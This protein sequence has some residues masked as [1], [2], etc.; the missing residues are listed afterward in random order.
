[1]KLKPECTPSFLTYF[2]TAL[3][4]QKYVWKGELN[5]GTYY[6]LPFTSGCKLKKRSKKNISIKTVELVYRTDSGEL[7][8]T[9]EL[10]L[11]CE[12]LYLPAPKNLI[13]FS[14]IKY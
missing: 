8:L 4:L 14:C 3:F 9:R 11:V 1:M 7:D 13:V 5:A 12:C 10:R 2:P 6:L